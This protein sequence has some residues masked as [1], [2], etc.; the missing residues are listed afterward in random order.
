MYY[1]LSSSCWLLL[2]LLA[3]RIASVSSASL[4]SWTISSSMLENFSSGRVRFT[5]V[6]R[7]NLSYMSAVSYTHLDVYKRQAAGGAWPAIWMRPEG[8]AWP[9][10][11]EIDIMERLN[12][13]SIAY[14]T[15]HSHYTYTLG[16]K[17]V[18]YT[19]LHF[20]GENG[21][22]N[23][24]SSFFPRMSLESLSNTFL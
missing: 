17:A 7:M 23:V 19:H 11:G 22:W 1:F 10:G 9:S 6:I 5:K 15:V 13:D 18:S 24:P 12:N 8:A 2:A 21:D 3:R 20:N 16:I 4:W 14:Q